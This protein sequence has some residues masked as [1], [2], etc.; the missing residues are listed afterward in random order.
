MLLKGKIYHFIF[1]YDCFIAIFFFVINTK[2]EIV[3]IYTERQKKLITL[4][5]DAH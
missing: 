4:Q 1:Q 5:G 3:Y 2:M